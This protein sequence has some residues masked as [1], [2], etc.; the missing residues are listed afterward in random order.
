MAFLNYHHLAYFRAIAREGSLS[1]AA[2]RLHVSA[3]ALSVQL[4][5]L[6]ES[7]GHPL[8]ERGR[9]GLRLTEAGRI[10]LDYAETIGRAGDEL[11]ETMQGRPREGRRVLRVGGV[12]TLSR[13]FQLSFL[14]PALALGKSLDL[15]LRSGSL[16]ELLLQ[17]H[18]HQLDVV[19]SNQPVKADA[20]HPWHSHLLDR[21][22]VSLVG[23]PDWK[24][25]RL[26]FPGS[27]GEVPL[28]LPTHENDTRSA[29]DRLLDSAG[30]R[31]RII[32]EVDDMSML[33][34]LATAGTGLALVPPVVVRDEIQRGQLIIR[35]SLPDIT[36]NFYAVTPSRRFPN[37][38]V[39]ELIERITRESRRA[40]HTLH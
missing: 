12:A 1:A 23:T 25:R 13:N 16:R 38:L 19:L 31:P 17:L 14:R 28:I 5:T 15:T 32:A 6:E 35:R 9:G 37:P 22:P 34:L 33:R 40:G 26:E 10:A 4:R 3:S 21:Q 29:F 36:E 8:F 7:L 30:I 20:E 24:A 11:L 27:L 18:A 39:R 2:E